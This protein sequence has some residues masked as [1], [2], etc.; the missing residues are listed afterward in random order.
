MVKILY[1]R[2]ILLSDEKAVDGSFVRS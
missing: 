2:I 1:R